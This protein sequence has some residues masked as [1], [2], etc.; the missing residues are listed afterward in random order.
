VSGRAYPQ[1]DA[2]SIGNDMH[3]SQGWIDTLAPQL[4]AAIVETRPPCLERDTVCDGKGDPTA[5]SNWRAVLRAKLVDGDLRLIVDVDGEP[6]RERLH[7]L[8]VD[9]F[10]GLNLNEDG[11]AMAVFR[12]GRTLPLIDFKVTPI[13]DPDER[14]ARELTHARLHAQRAET[15]PAAATTD[16]DELKRLRAFAQLSKAEAVMALCSQF[17]KM[18]EAVVIAGWL[19]AKGKT[20]DQIMKTTKRSR[21]TVSKRINQFYNATGWPKVDR[22]KG[23]GKTYQLDE[24]RDA[25]TV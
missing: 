25:A 23:I 11:A 18:P 7:G 22:R 12:G 15:K 13:T 8:S 3:A 10:E 5:F 2:H 6:E 17:D 16:P 20:W 1:T 19:H 4:R 9:T 21:G 14:Q 24:S